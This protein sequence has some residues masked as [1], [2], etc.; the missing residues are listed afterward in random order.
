M[1]THS[2]RLV[3]FVAVLFSAGAAWSQDSVTYTFTG[4]DVE[5]GATLNGIPVKEGQQVTIP[6]VVDLGNF[7][8]SESD[9]ETILGTGR[10]NSG[11]EEKRC[12]E[13]GNGGEAACVVGGTG[14]PCQIDE[15]CHNRRCSLNSGSPL[16]IYGGGGMMCDSSEGCS[17]L[18]CNFYDAQ[19]ACRR[20][21]SGPPCDAE[22][23]SCGDKWCGKRRGDN[24]E[25]LKVCLPASEVNGKGTWVKCESD[26][27]CNAETAK[28][29]HGEMCQDGPPTPPEGWPDGW[30]P[31]RMPRCTQDSDC[32]FKMCR[33]GS[34]L[35]LNG[36]GGYHTRSCSDNGDCRELRCFQDSGHGY[37]WY[38]GSG[39]PCTQAEGADECSLSLCYSSGNVGKRCLVIAG[40]GQMQCH[41]D[42]ECGTKKSA[43]PTQRPN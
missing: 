9:D 39:Q 33:I 28:F 42:E 1:I 17:E 4:K 37:C 11:D 14:M 36:W 43:P 23:V 29:C 20:G 38:G 10:T 31:D 26:D 18:R 5:R 32:R 7:E 15:Q 30:S 16:C 41:T 40:D 25:V 2:I 3:L 27:D 12:V 13:S 21:A 35:C 6:V 8:N 19:R 34:G 24:G 22:G